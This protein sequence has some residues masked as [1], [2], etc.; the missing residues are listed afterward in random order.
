MSQLVGYCDNNQQVKS[1]LSVVK[2]MST[3]FHKQGFVVEH[4][5]KQFLKFC[6]KHL[7][8]VKEWCGYLLFIKFNFWLFLHN[9]YFHS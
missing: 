7:K 2:M 9:F 4:L 3:K 1:L 6:E 8:I 5:K